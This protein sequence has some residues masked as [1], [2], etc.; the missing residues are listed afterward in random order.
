MTDLAPRHAAWASSGAVRRLA[1]WRAVRPASPAWSLAVALILAVMILPIVAVLVLAFT[2]DAN[3]WP[4]LLST[5]LPSSLLETAV[6][7]AGVG[8]LTL[9]TGATT[10]W[11]I[12]M[13]RFPGRGLLDRLLV[14]PLAV[15]TYIVAYCYVDLLDFTGPIQRG[16]R[17]LFGWHTARDYWFPDARG[18]GGAIFVISSV[19]YPYVYLTARASF[20]QQSVCALEVAR[21]LGRTPFG[22]FTSVA[23]PMAR[24]A[25]AAGT[26]LALMECLNDLGAVQYL[27]VRTLSASVYATWLQRSSLGGAAQIASLLLAL[28]VALFAMERLARGRS[29]FHNTSRRYRSVPFADLTGWRAAAACLAC[30]LPFACGFLLPFMILVLGALRHLSAMTD[31][32]IWR[33]AANSLLL[34]ALAAAAAVALAL[35]VGYARRVAPNPFTRP[36]VRLA[37]LGYALPGT[38]LALGL[39]IPLAA[40][41]NSADAFFRSTFGISTGLLITGSLFAL[42]LAYCVRFLAVSLGA[43][44]AGLEHISPSLDAAARTLGQSPFATLRRVHLP[45]LLP[46]LGTAGLLVFVDAMKE[47][48][49][50]LLLRPFNFE[51]LATYVYSFALLEQFEASS[52]GALAIVAAGLIPV[53]L[54]HNAVA[55]GHAGAQSRRSSAGRRTL[56]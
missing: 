4:H 44:E 37:G 49:T 46:A 15:P 32:G 55:G 12:T 16:L 2:A 6:L 3:V 13:Y 38:V 53:L 21:T 35:I 22:A 14:I 54:L 30:F 43:V 27:G 39:L 31:S 45:L 40:L 7:M 9:C 51:T 33:A 1:R 56:R 8:T 42:V 20:V 28:V 34:A 29:Q 17:A 18:M 52:V 24:P 36:A 25:L 48:P 47:L 5:V 11:V 26:A 19:L 41:D 50:T 10:A 23:L